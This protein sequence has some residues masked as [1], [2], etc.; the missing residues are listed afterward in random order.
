MGAI[1]Q[2]AEITS[3]WN[4]IRRFFCAWILLAFV[5]AYILSEEDRAELPAPIP[6]MGI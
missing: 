3:L 4:Y 5:A 2:M 1:G 6:Q